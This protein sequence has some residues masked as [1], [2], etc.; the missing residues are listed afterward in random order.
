MSGSAP[1]ASVIDI[2]GGI[3]NWRDLATRAATERR[4]IGVS[5]DAWAQALEAM[6]EHDTSI[7]IAA[8]L[9]RGD[10]IKSAG[11]LTLPLKNVP[12]G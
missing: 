8:I 6:G 10:E 4:A 11:G 7:V 5:P 2:D 1:G 12:Q 3:E 9:R